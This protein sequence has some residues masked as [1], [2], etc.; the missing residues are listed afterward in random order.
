M[1][2]WVNGVNNAAVFV[3]TVGQY[4]AP[5]YAHPNNNPNSIGSI[6]SSSDHV[7]TISGLPFIQYH[8]G[9]DYTIRFETPDF[10]NPPE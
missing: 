6:L 5:V 1:Y 4:K 3:F 8:V 10:R 2:T 9:G 7:S